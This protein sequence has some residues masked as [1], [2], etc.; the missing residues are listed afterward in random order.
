MGEFVLHFSPIFPIWIIIPL[1]LGAFYLSFL[2]YSSISESRFRKSLLIGLRVLSFIILGL[3]LFQPQFNSEFDKPI[4]PKLALLLDNSISTTIQNGNYK[5]LESYKPIL[6]EL[7]KMDTS[8]VELHSFAF[9]VSSKRIKNYSELDFLQG[10]TNLFDPVSKLVESDVDFSAAILVTDGNY[11]I[12]RDPLFA[13][14]Q[15]KFPIYSI[16]LGDTIPVRDVILKTVNSPAISYK[17]APFRIPIIVQRTGYTEEF[18][19]QISISDNGKTVAKKQ[20]FFKQNQLVLLDTLELTPTET[21]LK[22]WKVSIPSRIDEF[23]IQNNSASFSVRVLDNKNNILH[24]AF[25]IHPDLKTVRSIL[26]EVENVNLTSRTWIGENQYLEGKIN[27]QLIDSTQ[28]IILQGYPNPK[29]SAS[30][31]SAIDNW[32]EQKP[33]LFL[34]LPLQTL[35]YQSESGIDKKPIQTA[36]A[37]SASV[38]ELIINESE[39]NHPIL[40]LPELD[41]LS[42]TVN[43]IQR[44]NQ[45]SAKARSLLNFGLKGTDLQ[46]PAIAIAQQT[47]KRYTQFN[48]F[49]FFMLY[50]KGGKERD[51]ISALIKNAVEWTSTQVVNSLLEVEVPQREIQENEQIEIHATLKNESLQPVSNASILVQISSNKEIISTI[52][53]NPSGNGM[54][55]KSIGP[56]AE[57]VYHYSASAN[58]NETILDSDNGSFSVSAITNEYRSIQQNTQT[59]TNISLATNGKVI[60]FDKAGPF[61]DS[62][63]TQLIK[64]KPVEK[65]QKEWFLI[66]SWIWFVLLMCFL[67][68]EWGLRKLFALS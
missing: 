33:T 7:Y 64:S 23:T 2:T 53:L 56:F 19:V 54:Y 18:P 40:Q 67:T 24:V 30:L 16:A 29:L 44:G 48:F 22:R 51:W 49:D 28:L 39:L 5:G 45:L 15:A 35:G 34:L 65:I 41:L 13:T 31:K 57:G 62:L 8:E 26:Q 21:G 61:I 36:K 37:M 63:K 17:N 60:N 4:R 12:N 6:S 55:A 68:I 42:F 38:S 52:T 10:E 47:D 46:Q 59:L 3:V 1:L 50:Q 27:P 43:G 32:I 14:D 25:S 58:V 11:T 66:D 9:G 20:S